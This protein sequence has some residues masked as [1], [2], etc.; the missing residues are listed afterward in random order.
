MTKFYTNV[1]T[2]VKLLFMEIPLLLSLEFVLQFSPKLH[3]FSR[4]FHRYISPKAALWYT[5]S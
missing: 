5:Q 3:T 4:K 2:L 1:V